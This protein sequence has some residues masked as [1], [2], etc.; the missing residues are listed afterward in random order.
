MKILKVA[1]DGRW[2]PLL[3]RVVQATLIVAA[4]DNTQRMI[5]KAGDR[6]LKDEE[7]IV[8]IGD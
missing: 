7:K 3:S 8:I 1:K 5:E 6:N 4:V 2:H